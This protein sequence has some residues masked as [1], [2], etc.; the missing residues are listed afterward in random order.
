MRF[1]I[2]IFTL[3][4][5]GCSCH[6]GHSSIDSK[7]AHI[8]KKYHTKI[9][10][11]ALHIES[12]KVV[13]YK[14][15]DR[16]PMAST[17]KVPIGIY[18]LSKVQHGSASLDTMVTVNQYDLVP[19]CGYMGYYLT[20]PG[21][22]MSVYNMLEPMITISDNTASDMILRR[23]GGPKSVQKFLDHNNIQDIKISRYLADQFVE[24]KGAQAFMPERKKWILQDVMKIFANL[25][26]KEL[27]TS[28]AKFFADLDKDS[29]TPKAMSLLLEKLYKREL[30]NEKYTS[31]MLEIM[32]RTVHGRINTLLP[33]DVKL[34]HKTGT[35]CFQHHNYTH[36]VGIITSED[37]A[38]HIV[39]SVYTGS[40]DKRSSMKMQ[41]KAISEIS[42]L[43]YDAVSE[44]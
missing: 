32:E 10:V 1:T 3:L 36:D 20:R 23:V 29:T 17:V 21:L 34:A 14:S 25:D 16:F 2:V 6:K 39:I 33:K 38:N 30:L 26:K 41:E 24:A 19:Y 22:A 28:Y 13:D 43:V 7:I 35:W 9:G 42:K 8:E 5:A 12:G 37:S 31:L 27:E 4:L 11:S 40:N 18:L 15:S 44:K